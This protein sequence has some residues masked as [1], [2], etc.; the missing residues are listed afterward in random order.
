MPKSYVTLAAGKILPPVIVLPVMLPA[1]DIDPLLIMLPEFIVPVSTL[2]PVML[3][4]AL[5]MPDVRKLP[6]VMLAV[7]TTGPVRD[8]KLPVYV[9]RYA[10][11]LAFE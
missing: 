6:P 10:A 8:T 1:A 2:P 4:A 7:V 5:I 9:G 3:P 11:T